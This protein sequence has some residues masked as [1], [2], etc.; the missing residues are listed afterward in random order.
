MDAVSWLSYFLSFPSAAG[1]MELGAVSGLQIQVA[2]ECMGSSG[3]GEFAD[4]DEQCW[5][6]QP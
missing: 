3:M 6:G 4:S 1:N 5:V 2:V